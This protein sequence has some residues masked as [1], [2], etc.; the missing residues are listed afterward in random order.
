MDLRRQNSSV[1]CKRLSRKGTTDARPRS[2][3]SGADGSGAD[4]NMDGNNVWRSNIE[5]TTCAGTPPGERTLQGLDLRR[6]RGETQGLDLR[7]ERGEPQGLD[8]QHGQNLQGLQTRAPQA[9]LQGMDLQK[10]LQAE[11]A[12]APLEQAATL[13]QGTSPRAAASPA[14]VAPVPPR[15][16]G[17]RSGGSAAAA[18]GTCAALAIQARR[19]RSKRDECSAPA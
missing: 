6:G 10:N 1:F 2:P 15:C 3:I 11:D 14:P 7:G 17:G 13:E 9:H 12:G 19:P 8:L 16:G 4:A 5:N 18:P